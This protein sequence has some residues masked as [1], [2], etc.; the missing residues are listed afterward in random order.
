MITHNNAVYLLSNIAKL[1]FILFVVF[2]CTNYIP[3][4]CLISYIISEIYSALSTKRTYTIGA[5]QKSAK[6]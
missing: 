2:V 3:G 5:L 1:F 6:C 4:L